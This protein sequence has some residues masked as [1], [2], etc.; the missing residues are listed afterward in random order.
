MPEGGGRAFLEFIE[1]KLTPHIHERF[2]TDP[3][4]SVLVGHSLGGLFTIGASTQSSGKMLHYL[5]LS[6]SLWWDDRFEQ[7]LFENTLKGGL[8]NS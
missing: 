5:A 6:P 8:H 2:G 7:K 3:D 1:G 4:V